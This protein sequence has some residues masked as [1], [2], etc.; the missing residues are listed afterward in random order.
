MKKII[1]FTIVLLITA[2]SV[3]A[4]TDKYPQYYPTSNEDLV[5]TI[6]DTINLYSTDTIGVFTCSNKIIYSYDG[7]IYPDAANRMITTVGGAQNANVDNTPNSALCKLLH[8]YHQATANNLSAVVSSYAP[9]CRSAIETILAVDSIRTKF[10][11]GISNIDSLE[12][13]TYYKPDDIY[14]ISVVRVYSNDN[15]S[16][17]IPYA[18]RQTNGNWFVSTYSDETGLSHNITTFLNSY[19]GSLLERNSDIDV[20]GINN[21]EDNCPCNYNPDQN[22][23]DNDGIGDSCDNCP[24]KYNPLQNDSDGDGVGDE[25]DNCLDTPNPD[26]SDPDNDG[27]G[28]ECDNCPNIFNPYQLDSDGDGIGNECDP[29]IDGDGIPNEEDGDMD[30]DGVPNEEDN[31]PTTYNPSQIDSDEDGIGDICDNCPLVY[32]PDQTDTDG[33]GVGDECDPDIDGDGIPNEYDNC[34]YIYNPDQTDTNCDGV[35]DACQ[36]RNNNRK[37]NRKGKRQ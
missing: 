32:N 10:Y 30:C 2:F 21:L 6:M 24:N 14:L 18:L 33:D 20:D 25:C 27:L 11:D 13:Y 23:S 19:P 17:V 3:K 26:Q 7:Y 29:D 35:G 22:D 5:I 1:S 15:T 31:C 37:S 8:A 28:D 36:E 16:C 9:E 12:L 4:Q 34:P